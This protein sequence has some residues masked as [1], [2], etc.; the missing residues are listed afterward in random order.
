MTTLTSLNL[1]CNRISHLPESFER[2]QALQNLDLSSNRLKSIPEPIMKIKGLKNLDLS[3][4]NI[5]EISPQLVALKHLQ[6]LQLAANNLSKNLPEFFENF[7]SLIKIDLRFNRIASINSLKHLPA[8]EVITATGNMI[9][10]FESAAMSF[11]QCYL[12]ST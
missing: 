4:N 8:L 3:Y 12:N 9:S 7:T 2:L 10:V 1:A 6:V 11:C 5:T